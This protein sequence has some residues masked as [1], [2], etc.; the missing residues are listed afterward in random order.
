MQ[1]LAH[2]VP[3]QNPLR[4]TLYRW[5]YELARSPWAFLVVLLGF[6][7]GAATFTLFPMTTEGADYVRSPAHLQLLVLAGVGGLLWWGVYLINGLPAWNWVQLSPGLV[8]FRRYGELE[9]LRDDI[10]EIRRYSPFYKPSWLLAL[11]GLASPSP[12]STRWAIPPSGGYVLKMK[13][14]KLGHFGGW[15]WWHR[16]LYFAPRKAEGFHQSL[17][18]WWG[19]PIS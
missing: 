14:R 1:P 7:G 4:V 12:F 11:G 17:E 19:V 10:E 9:I 16:N 3:T 13:Q 5:D 15:F 18:E 8:R 2:S 6:I